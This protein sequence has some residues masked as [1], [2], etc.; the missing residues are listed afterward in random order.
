MQPTLR[1]VFLGLSITS[2]WGNG[3]AT[4]YRGLVAALARRGHEVLFLERDAP[5]YARHRD[6]TKLAG[7]RVELYGSV[8]DLRRRFTREIRRAHVV[9]VGSYVPEG[10][11]VGRWVRAAARGLVAFYDIDTPVTLAALE[12]DRCAYLSRRLLAAYDLYLSFSGGPALCRL[13]RLGARMPRPLYC[14]V[15]PAQYLPSGGPAAWDL[16]YLGTYAADRQPAH[17]SLLLRV[18]DGWADGRFVVG[19]PLYPPDIRWPANVER[20]EH[21]PPA[22]HSRFYGR[23]RF[24]LNLTRGDMRRLGHSPSVRLFE[25]AACGAAILT[26]DWDGLDEFFT[27]GVDLIRVRTARDVVE[28]LRDMPEERRA[29]LGRSARARV[30]ASHTADDRARSLEEYAFELL[31]ARL[32]ATQAAETFRRRSRRRSQPPARPRVVA[33]RRPATTDKDLTA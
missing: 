33:A 10:R 22:D 13:D 32:G 19:G 2:S 4:T 25:A 23:Q 28:A 31:E 11:R 20:T 3:H 6:L 5:W 17:E 7:A 9:V 27:P 26:D 12:T 30:L 1:F 29:A 16:G 24:T 8:V 21:V 18:A 14:A 15:D